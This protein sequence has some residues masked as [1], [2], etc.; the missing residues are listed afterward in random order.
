V[1]PDRRAKLVHLLP[2]RRI[3]RPIERLA[4]DI[5]VDLHAERAIL[6]RAFGFT[7]SGIRCIK[8]D[9]RDPTWKAVV[10]LGDEL[11]E[12]VV[13][14]AAELVDILW[15]LGK[16]LD[17]RLRIGQDLLIVLKAVHDLLAEIEI[18]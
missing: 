14:D 13:D 9:L 6:Q 18:V 1:H 5:G 2:E 12:A 17:R 4:G 7:N 10:F 3:L 16:A 8:R 15:R 11:G